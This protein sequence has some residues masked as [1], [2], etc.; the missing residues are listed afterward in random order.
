[1]VEI[2]VTQGYVNCYFITIIALTYQLAGH[3]LSSRLLL[4][5]ALWSS[6][7]HI[8]R[9]TMPW[10]LGLAF[11]FRFQ[12]LLCQYR[13]FSFTTDFDKQVNEASGRW[14]RSQI[15]NGI[16]CEPYAN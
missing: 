15:K 5:Q 12:L 13:L 11:V 3:F 2:H 7:T 14:G 16:S 4:T 1:M 6:D 10:V 9:L 8:V